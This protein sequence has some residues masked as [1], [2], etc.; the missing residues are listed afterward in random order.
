[1]NTR[2]R[3]Q[4]IASA[5]GAS[6]EDDILAYAFQELRNQVQKLKDPLELWRR[7]IDSWKT[8]PEEAITTA[9]E[10]G[11]TDVASMKCAIDAALDSLSGLEA[12]LDCVEAEAEAMGEPA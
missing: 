12:E 3:L 11:A 5:V 4:D 9:I 6:V 8:I 2:E 7:D 10:Y 1:M